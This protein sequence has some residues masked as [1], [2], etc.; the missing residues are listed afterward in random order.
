MAEKIFLSYAQ[1]DRKIAERI[2]G[3][4]RKHG[5]VTSPE[6]EF[7]DP[8]KGIQAGDNIRAILK[9][10]IAASSTVVIITSPNSAQSQW[11]SYEAGMASALGKP[12]VVVGV[13]GVGSKFAQAL[14]DVR[15]IEIKDED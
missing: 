6:V 7:F 11:V 9:N 3:Y 12:I 8:Q 10:E 4:L 2:E 13:G 5:I 1:Q 15:T 14:G